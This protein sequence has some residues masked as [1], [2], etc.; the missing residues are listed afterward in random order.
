MADLSI[1][2][3]NVT[4]GADATIDKSHNAGA[5]VNAGE[6][7]Y[8]DAVTDT[9]KLADAN[10]D[11]YTAVV[12]GFALNTAA[13]GQPLTVQTSGILNVGG[14][15]VVVGTVYVQSGTAG[16]VAPAADLVSGWRTS[17]VAIGKTTSS[18]FLAIANSGA[19]VP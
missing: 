10:Q 1:T 6:T 2:A 12:V 5:A 3:S 8:L 18:L 16:K 11:A 9:W 13:V 7:V 4:K 19:Q 17:T 14:S 15:S